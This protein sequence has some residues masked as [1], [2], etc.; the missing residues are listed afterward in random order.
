MGVT[1]DFAR[2]EQTGQQGGQQNP[3]HCLPVLHQERGARQFLTHAA[4]NQTWHPDLVVEA[5]LPGR[6]GT[7]VQLALNVVPQGPSCNR[8]SRIP[9]SSP[10]LHPAADRPV[11]VRQ[12]PA[13]RACSSSRQ[14]PSVHHRD[15]RRPA[16]VGTSR[17]KHSRWARP[18]SDRAGHDS[19]S[20]CGARSFDQII[21]LGKIELE[22][23]KR[24]DAVFVPGPRPTDLAGLAVKLVPHEKAQDRRRT[25]LAIH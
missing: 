19:V 21:V 13:R 12:R 17:P 24:V 20:G 1:M 10:A 4:Y 14:V 5:C 7:V 3:T 11:S 16:S 9:T 23:E 22:T 25:L 18:E 8:R 2:L 6:L 15:R